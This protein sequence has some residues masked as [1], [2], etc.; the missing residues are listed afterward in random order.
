MRHAATLGPGRFRNYTCLWA[1]RMLRGHAQ[2]GEVAD[3]LK[4]H[5]ASVRVPACAPL[6][7]ERT[8][9]ARSMVRFVV[10]ASPRAWFAWSSVRAS[11]IACQ[12]CSTST[13]RHPFQ[14]CYQLT[15][16][17]FCTGVALTS[18]KQEKQNVSPLP[19]P[20]YHNKERIK[21]SR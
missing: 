6:V 3:A 10:A 12:S 13:L 1:V 4:P 8:A 11:T 5:L 15:R 7:A 20:T 17:T 14:S 21:R 19:V 9:A 16:H 18:V 2:R